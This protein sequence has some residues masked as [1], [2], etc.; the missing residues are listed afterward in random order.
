LQTSTRTFSQ[1]S[2]EGKPSNTQNVASQ[3]ELNPVV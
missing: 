2:I 3:K 1:W